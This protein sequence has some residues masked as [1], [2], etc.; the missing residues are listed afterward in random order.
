MGV[1]QNLVD[2]ANG[3]ATEGCGVETREPAAGRTTGPERR[4]S[5]ASTRL[6]SAVVERLP[7]RI[8]PCLR[9]HVVHSGGEGCEAQMKTGCV[10]R[11]VGR[12]RR[13]EDMWLGEARRQD[14]RHG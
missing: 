8:A 13:R 7:P 3:A 11:V 2:V 6:A 5:P 9:G 1:R 12:G 10:D 14:A 4:Q